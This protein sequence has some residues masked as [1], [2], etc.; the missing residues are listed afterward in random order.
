[1]ASGDW[2]GPAGFG[3]GV[4][5]FVWLGVRARLDRPRLRVSAAFTLEFN[6]SIVRYGPLAVNFVNHGAKPVTVNEVYGIERGG[7]GKVIMPEAVR[8]LPMR[9]ENGATGNLPLCPPEMLDRLET[10]VVT[11]TLGRKYKVSRRHMKRLMKS[12]QEEF[13]VRQTEDAVRVVRRDG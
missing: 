12:R 10:I 13:E 6:E 8:A 9:L 5:N 11:D 4:L 1:M 7:G 3:L 2:V